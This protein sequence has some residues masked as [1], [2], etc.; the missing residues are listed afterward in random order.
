MDADLAVVADAY[1]ATAFA[2]VVA[3]TALNSGEAAE[4][5]AGRAEVAVPLA[6][7]AGY[8]VAPVNCSGV[9]AVIGYLEVSVHAVNVCLEILEMLALCLSV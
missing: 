4:M 2:G 7:L 5:T 6:L 1:S 3:V 8:L 9:D